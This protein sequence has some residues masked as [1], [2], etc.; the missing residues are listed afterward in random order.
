MRYGV[1]ALV[2]VT[3]GCIGEAA[4]PAPRY[5]PTVE[6]TPEPER[7]ESGLDGRSPW[8]TTEAQ[9][10]V[11]AR[12]ESTVEPLPLVHCVDAARSCWTLVR[13][14]ACACP[15]PVTYNIRVAYLD[16]EPKA[17]IGYVDFETKAAVD[18]LDLESSDQ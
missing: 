17:A 18:Y 14:Q 8:R 4:V 1:L 2:A 6:A 12:S 13:G 16:F 7:T 9:H 15:A 5:L 11:L 3:T 10:L